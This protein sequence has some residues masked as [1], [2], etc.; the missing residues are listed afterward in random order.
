VRVLLT[1]ANGF[2]GRW[3]T[4]ELAAANHEAIALDSS[5]DIRDSAAVSSA[6]A[7]VQPDAIAHLAAVAFGP[8]ASADPAT[9]YSVA[10]GGTRSV[11]EAA[12]LLD[13]SPVVL[14]TG[15]SE[16]YGQPQE[17]DLP[18]RE[19]AALN[20]VSPYSI[21]KIAQESVALAYSV[22]HGIPVIVTRSF[23]HIGP[24]Q[25]PDFVVPAI[26]QR[27]ADAVA[28]GTDTIAVGNVDVR[29]DISDVR[30]VVRAYRLLLEAEAKLRG[31]R[32]PTVVNVCSGQSVAIRWVAERFCQ[33]AGAHL[34][35]EVDPSL[36]RAQDA[37]EIRG[38]YAL[39]AAATGWRPTTSIEDSLR[40]VWNATTPSVAANMGQ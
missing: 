8:D 37:K 23:N 24:G 27:V 21:S 2:V 3:L 40:D 22:R 11:L 17:G 26:A 12:R 36:A 14:V 18:L 32:P 7:S 29:R 20:G 39:L 9:A 19:S 28:T 13:Q 30:D 25:R 33:F 38:D 10:I 4:A 16:V 1:G 35:L 5:I 31:P 34:A 15:S 6:V